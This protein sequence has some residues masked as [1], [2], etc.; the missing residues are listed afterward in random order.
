LSLGLVGL[1]AIGLGLCFPLGLRL[2]A[3]L[4]RT[5]EPHRAA[6]GPWLWGING[7]FGV[8]GSSLGLVL[9]MTHGI[10]A[11]LLCGASCY[12]ILPLLTFRL[13]RSAPAE[14]SLGAR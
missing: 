2:A 10:S 6:L 5:S 7:A 4:E 9:S 8:C 11:T 13:A 14:S 12:L 1:P 3:G